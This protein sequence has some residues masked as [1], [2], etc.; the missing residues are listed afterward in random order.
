[1]EVLRRGEEPAHFLWRG[2][3]YAVR[4]V[5][6]HWVETGPWWGSVPVR[7]LLTAD[8]PFPGAE[9]RTC[10]ADQAGGGTVLDVDDSDRELWRVEAA[11]GRRGEP[12]V[13]DLCFNWSAGAWTLVRTFD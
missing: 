10:S 11:Q 5:L 13:Y 2:R 4:G 8:D 12:G 1:M 6:A 3:L 7:A 9:Q